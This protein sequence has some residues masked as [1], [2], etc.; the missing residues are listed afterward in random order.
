MLGSKL[1]SKE[2]RKSSTEGIIIHFSSVSGLDPMDHVPI[3]SA[4]KHAVVGFCRAYSVIIAKLFLIIFQEN[5]SNFIY[6]SI[7]LTIVS[8]ELK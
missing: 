1:M 5:S 3:Y 4:S 8:V 2:K 6:F 7:K